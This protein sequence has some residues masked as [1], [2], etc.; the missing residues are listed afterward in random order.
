MTVNVVGVTNAQYITV[1]LAG[2]NDGTNTNDVAVRMGILVGDANGD[3]TVNSAD[4][5]LTKSKSGQSVDS[6]NF[7]EDLNADG[8]L[9]SGDVGLV[10]SKSGTG[11]P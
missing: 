9:N 2:V 5:G 4:V 8:G 3:R 11:L 10:K 1:T 7:R 6:T